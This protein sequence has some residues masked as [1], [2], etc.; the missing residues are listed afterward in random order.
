MD[1]VHIH[2]E[3]K[4]DGPVVLLTHGF[5]A[6]SHMFASTV[7]ALAPDHTAIAWDMP[8]HGRSDAPDDASAYSTR[9]FLDH[10]LALVDGAGA[11]QAVVLGHSLGGYLS[12]ELALAH[13]DRVRGVVLVD[14]GPGYRNDVARDGWNEMATDYAVNLE[15]KG[16]D[17]LPGGAELSRGVHTSAVGL[18][19]TARNVLTQ[20]DSHVIDG[21]PTITAPT[22]VVV[23]S[24][25]AP[26][27][28]GSHYMAGKVPQA[29]LVVID[30][31]GHAPPVTHPE[32]FNVALRAYLEGLR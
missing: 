3:V 12:L 16:L 26:F 19:H 32:P 5:A 23:G 25:D 30:G 9:R 22:L 24:D 17:G 2:S 10:M 31:C 21:L 18:A 14:T 6:S 1:A 13:P 29:E 4:G 15:T 28:K 27:V 7:Q 20:R 11:E 8:G